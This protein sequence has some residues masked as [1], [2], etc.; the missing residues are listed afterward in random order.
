MLIEPEQ[1]TFFSNGVCVMSGWKSTK[2]GGKSIRWNCIVL[3]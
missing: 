1:N 3:P 2:W